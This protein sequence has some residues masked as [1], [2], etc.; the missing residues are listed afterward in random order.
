MHTVLQLAITGL[1]SG[2]ATA[3]LALGL[4]LTYRGS[5]V[6]NFAQGAIATSA[7]YTFLVLVEE[8]WSTLPAAA[9]SV[10][11]AVAIGVAF[12][13]LVLRNLRTAPPMAKVIATIG[14]LVTLVALVPLVFGDEWR[15][16]VELVDRTA[17]DLGFGDP[18]FVF[19]FDRLVFLLVAIAATVVLWAIYRFTTFGRAT[20]AL[21]DNERAV[22]LLGY[23]TDTLAVINWGLGAALAG[24]AG[25]LLASLVQQTPM[26]Y[27]LILGGAIAAALIA[28]FRSFAVTLVACLLLGSVQAVVQSIAPDLTAVTTIGGWG[29]LI[30]LIV[31]VVV[32]VVRGRSIPV[33]GA[34]LETV[35]PAAPAIRSPLRFAAI[36]IAVGLVWMIVVPAAWVAPSTIS[37]IGGLVCLSL[38]V[39]TGYLGQVS[40]AQM[41][42]A[43]SGA[44]FAAQAASSLPF[45]IPLLI[46]GLAAVPIGWLLALPALRIRGINLA[47]VTMAAAFAAD[48]AFFTD[49]RLAGGSSFERPSLG[50]IELNPVTSPRSFAVVVLIVVLLLCL[51]V[52]WLR[53]SHIGLRLLAVRAN[54]RG[55]AALGLSNAR[56]KLVAFGISAFIAGVSGALLGY[57]AE[58]LSYDNFGAFLSL[59]I[60]STAYMAGIGA[61]PSVFIGGLLVSGGLLASWLH[62]PGVAGQ[63]VQVLGGVGVM[64]TVIMH[65]S[66]LALLPHDMREKLQRRRIAHVKD[67][68]EAAPVPEPR[69]DGEKEPVADAPSRSVSVASLLTHRDDRRSL[70]A[71]HMTLS[72]GAVTAVNDVSLV[73]PPGQLVGLIGPNGAGKTSTID[74][75]TGFAPGTRGSVRLGEVEIGGWPAHKRARAGLIRTFQGLEIFDDLTVRENLEV[76]QRG[77]A[78]G[79]SVSVDD[80]LA[81]FDL[82]ADAE[83]AAASLP[84]GERRMLALA[85]A[86]ACGPEVLVLDE[87]AAGLD[88]D[89]SAHLGTLLRGVVDSGLGV[90]LVDHDM[91]LVLTVCD[92]VLVMDFGHVIATGD[93]NSIRRDELVLSAYLGG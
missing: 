50:G 89:E 15:P 30:P 31:I 73:V 1:G 39:L 77:I 57:Q 27:T 22:T 11:I 4:V 54:E 3:L 70:V 76:A 53:R 32:M 80:A 84:Q 16:P 82:R 63:I 38:V 68:A 75:L 65:P 46:G 10:A 37:L 49:F 28:N 7:A 24:G 90:L 45:P 2:A 19:P 34:L 48:A 12:Q 33:R 66:G 88:S 55:A 26:S 92:H 51:G 23:S 42:L 47:V 60:V 91:S 41:F 71:E 83:R 59:V 36:G 20:R 93:P 81:A 58:R 18:A 56:A 85:R 40:L 44:F 43:G 17:I 13:V 35:L 9:V 25:V 67:G 14:L 78:R 52:A 72:Y 62:F 86:L 21:A 5:G 61:I 6:V 69:A 74:A 29:E 64:L 8:D 79:S 87:P